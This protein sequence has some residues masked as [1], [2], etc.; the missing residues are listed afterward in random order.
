MGSWRTRRIRLPGV[1]AQADAVRQCCTPAADSADKQCHQHIEMRSDMNA[2]LDEAMVQSA[3]FAERVHH[4]QR[5]LRIQLRRQYDFTVCGSGSSGSVVARRLAE[6][7]D[8]SVLL[9]EAGDDDNVPAVMRA[10]QWPANLGSER[11]WNFAAQPNPHLDAR[12]IP[13]SMGKVLGGRSSING[14]ALARGHKN[15]WDYFAAKAGDNA[16]NYESVLNIYRRIEDWHGA[17][18]GSPGL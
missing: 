7:P 2:D 17:R 11:D 10:E 4:V 1:A 6:N 5:R 18:P 14:M 3:D 13:H 9:E 12:S 16:W 15:D 8:V